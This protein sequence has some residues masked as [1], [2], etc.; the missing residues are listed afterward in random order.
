MLH[1]GE[2]DVRALGVDWAAARA[3]VAGTVRCVARG[4]TAQPLKP[5]LLYGDPQNRIIAMPA[6]VGGE[7]A[8]AG[9]KWIASFPG[10]LARGLPR[11]H[12]V[13]IL[14]DPATGVPVCVV[15]TALVSVVRTAAVSAFVLERFRAAHDRGRARVGI[16]GWGPIGRMHARMCAA[17]L[18]P[19][20][21]ALRVYD[22]HGVA[23]ATIPEELA[24]DLEV[25]ASW[26]DVYRRSD[27]VVTATVA[28]ARYVD[29]PPAPGAL[30]LDVS[31]RDYHPA[32]ADHV[33]AIVVDDWDDVC[34][35][36][37]DIERLHRERGLER[38]DTWS[39]TDLLCGCLAATPPEAPVLVCPMGM[40]VFDVA[41]AADYFRR[42]SAAGIG[43]ALA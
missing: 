13:T 5:Y 6:W 14:N 29:G 17:V 8:A 23:P 7:V 26:R 41:I 11:A 16:V 37:T 15:T 22:L 21:A 38:A 2:A 32:I 25:C 39:F 12:S 9:I 36:D 4:A 43:T 31:L 33:G 30:L 34:R 20:L 40:G 10:N 1:L 18:G 35:E 28:E 19:D 24:G 27:V 42:A 3:L